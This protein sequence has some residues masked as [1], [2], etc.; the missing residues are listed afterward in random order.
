[1]PSR[2]LSSVFL[3]AALSATAAPGEK[4]T[5]PVLLHEAKPEYPAGMK[6]WVLDPVR[7][8]LGLDSDGV[9]FALRSDAGLPDY[10]VAALA[11]FR[12]Q[13]GRQAVVAFILP[14]RRPIDEDQMRELRRIVRLWCMIE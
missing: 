8:G 9:P 12:Y 4:N 6:A 2:F 5:A 14:V 7:I 11:Q 13:R 3:V 1:M 10:V